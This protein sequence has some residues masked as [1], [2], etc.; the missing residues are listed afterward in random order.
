MKQKAKE[1]RLRSKVKN[2][3][4]S[5]DFKSKDG[6]TKQIN[7]ITKFI[8]AAEVEKEMAENKDGLPF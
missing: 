7:H 1:A 6:A 8:D 3:E 4:G 5:G 2:W